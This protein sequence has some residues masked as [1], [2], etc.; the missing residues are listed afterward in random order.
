MRGTLTWPKGVE[1]KSFFMH[2]GKKNV[3]G[4]NQVSMK[5]MIDI[6]YH[7]DAACLSA[8]EVVFG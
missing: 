6:P 7:H 5:R 3:G 2:V 4:C 1:S 8:C